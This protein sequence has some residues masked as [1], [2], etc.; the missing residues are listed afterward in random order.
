MIPLEKALNIIDKVSKTLLTERIKIKSEYEE[1]CE[2]AQDQ[3]YLNAVGME[4]WEVRY[5][6]EKPMSQ[7]SFLPNDSYFNNLN[8]FEFDVPI[9]DVI[10]LNKNIISAGKLLLA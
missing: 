9:E 2:L 5:I 3:E 8:I 10:F 7:L 1:I 4:P 6:T